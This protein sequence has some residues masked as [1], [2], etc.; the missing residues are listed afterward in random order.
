[1]DKLVERFKR[2]RKLA[3]L[4]KTHAKCAKQIRA[5]WPAGS[6]GLIMSLYA[7]D[8]AYRAARAAVLSNPESL[9]RSMSVAATPTPGTSNRV[10][11]FGR[12]MGKSEIVKML[13][14]DLERS[15]GL[16]EKTF[17]PG[18][19]EASKLEAEKIWKGISE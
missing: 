3:R 2:W 1:M 15:S 9:K 6:F 18:D 7:N 12:Q 4:K 10:V 13:R 16:T 14:E 17:E 11:M 19:D 5:E 8:V